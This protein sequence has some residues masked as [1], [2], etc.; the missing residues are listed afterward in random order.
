MAQMIVAPQ[1]RK[2]VNRAGAKRDVCLPR[3]PPVERRAP[4]DARS[5]ATARMTNASSAVASCAAA[6]RSPSENHAR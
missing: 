1:P 6:A 4:R 5:S 3:G 2:P